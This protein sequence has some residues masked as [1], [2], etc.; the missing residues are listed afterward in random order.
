M[1]IKRR[2]AGLGILPLAALAL[3]SSASARPDPSHLVLPVPQPGFAGEIRETMGES[4]PMPYRH[5]RPPAGAPNIFLFMADDVGFSMSST[6]G[7][8]VP[9]P[10]MDRLARGGQ[11]YNRFHS[12]GV[13]SPSRAALLTGRNPHRVGTGHIV[14][15]AA[16]YPGY[17]G[18][19]PASAATIAQTLQLN[20][21]NTAMFGKHHNVPP[22]EVSDA[23]PFHM[24]PTGIGFEYFYGFP[25]GESDQFRPNVYRGT[26]RLPAASGK[27]ELFE[28]RMADD[29][30]R[31][32][33]NHIAAA[34]DRPFFVYYSPGSTHAPHQAPPELIARFKGRFDQGWDR[35]R[36]ETFRRQKA[37]GIIPQDARLT[38]RPES[39]PAWDSLSG[40]E[41]AYALRGMEVAAAMLAYQD[42]QLGRVLD[43]MERTGILDDTLVIVIQGDNGASG[44][45]DE[46]GVTDEMFA[47]NFV[48]EGEAD[49]AAAIE[50]LGSEYSHGSYAEGWGWAMNAPFP[51]Y[52]SKAGMLGALRDGM[53]VSWTGHVA[54]PGGICDRF[55]HLVDIA[56]TLL[57]AAAIPAPESVFGVRQM[58]FDGKSL[59]DSL[60]RCEGGPARTQYFEVGGKAGLYSEG[61]MIAS[62]NNAVSHFDPEAA[63]LR[64]DEPAAWR[65]YDLDTDYSQS[66]DVTEK[67]PERRDALYALWR[68][69]AVRNN[70][71]PIRSGFA[72]T[73]VQSEPRKRFDFWG[74]DVSIP[75]HP[76]GLMGAHLNRGFNLK[77]DIELPAAGTS[78]VIMALGSR[79]SGWSLF[80]EQGRPVFRFARSI[81]PGDTTSVTS[82]KALPQG[83][84]GLELRFVA[85]GP[86]RPA[87]AEIGANGEVLASGDIPGNLV[88][89]LG[90]GENL[91]AGRDTGAA[92]TEYAREEG[93]FE[94]EIHHIVIEYD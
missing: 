61:W 68:K 12:A 69:E 91:D 33:R 89:P 1:A 13:C 62:T 24:W 23:G 27:V 44:D 4:T 37:M 16:G 22:G 78:G 64:I 30:M 65:L 49:R 5:V 21:Y 79:F 31:W 34:P 47:M 57:E 38:P 19:F 87:R 50:K 52:K 53:I 42:E 41:R 82:A 84:N 77:A 59:L 81:R 7:G 6:F 17:D 3:V 46:A 51:W 2:V 88:M 40:T 55:G 15:L 26:N 73:Q 11:R 39:I 80:L 63:K 86:A 29:T 28:K 72:P 70:V 25:H 67:F 45:G 83:A 58:S 93:R 92:V 71:L 74:K 20:G 9:T 90:V 54:N 35:A 48:Q 75:A 85:D 18:H 43:E 32:L 94:G 10:N 56:P 36:G 60:D 8:P 66:R 76:D 14:D